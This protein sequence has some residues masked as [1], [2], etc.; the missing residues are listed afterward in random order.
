MF[1]AHKVVVPDEEAA[2]IEFT[3]ANRKHHESQ[4][5][6]TSRLKAVDA[7]ERKTAERL[8]LIAAAE[9]RHRVTEAERYRLLQE[10]LLAAQ[11]QEVSIARSQ[12]ASKRMA[13]DVVLELQSKCLENLA[14]NAEDCCICMSEPR[15]FA[16]IPCGHCYFCATCINTHVEKNGYSCPVC[17]TA[18]SQVCKIHF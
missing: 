14:A 12:L 10:D 16:T 6:A 11:E 7:E 15:E 18:V 5:N 9:E 17:R 1:E 4:R 8:A 3:D 2:P 13:E